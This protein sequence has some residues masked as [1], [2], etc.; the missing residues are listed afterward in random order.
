MKIERINIYAT[1][2]STEDPE[3]VAEA[4][5]TLIPFE[6][7]IQVS[8]AEGHF[9]NPLEF[10]EVE[11]KKQREIKEFLNFFLKEIESQKR[12][13][14]DELPLRIDENGMLHLRVDKQQAYLGRIALISHGDGI[15]VRIK[16]TTYPLKRE[17]VLEAAREMLESY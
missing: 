8:K 4:I 14:L 12:K 1:V 15:I 7:E 13:L 10:L 11:I 5:A 3:K 16:I 2:H 17:K 6:F 9:G